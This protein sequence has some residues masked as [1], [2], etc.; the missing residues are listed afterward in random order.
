MLPNVI[1]DSR[2]ICVSGIAERQRPAQT[3]TQMLRFASGDI[4]QKN[5]IELSSYSHKTNCRVCGD[6][7]GSHRKDSVYCNA[8]CRQKAHRFRELDRK[9]GVEPEPLTEP[10][11]KMATCEYEHCNDRYEAKRMGSK[12]CSSRCRVANHR[13]LQRY[14]RDNVYQNE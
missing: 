6:R 8:A 4:M 3:V 11:S 9:Y 1:R 5:K 13:W 2:N 12:F 10:L 14:Y 7:F